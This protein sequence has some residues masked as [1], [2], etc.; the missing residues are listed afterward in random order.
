VAR[1]AGKTALITGAGS[2]FGEGMAR[3]FA[4]EGA[5]VAIVDVRADQAQRVAAAIG[6]AALAIEADVSS[7]EA[8]ASAVQQTVAAFGVPHI[9]VNNAGVTHRNRPVLEVDE[10]TF[11]RILA[12]NVKSIFHMVRATVP[13]MRDHG[14]GVMLNVGSTA[15]MRPRPGLTWYN[16][17]K[18]AV[19]LV[20]KSLAVELAPWKIRVNALCP[21]MGVTGMLGDFMGVEDTPENRARFLA[22]I[23]LGRLSQ[24]DDIA[25]AALFLASDEAAFITGVEL[26]LDGGRT[27]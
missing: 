4:A 1:L 10:A 15:G 3:R 23:P 21:V 2:G 11:D 17:S 19:N 27:V 6:D 18:G 14:G 20:S 7:G 22:T 5:R 26:P 24:P 9:V 13:L 25:A 16:A 12:V 8:V